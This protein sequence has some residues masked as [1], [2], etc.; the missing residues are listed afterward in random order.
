MTQPNRSADE[1]RERATAQWTSASSEGPYDSR[2]SRSCQRVCG[3]DLPPGTGEPP[4]GISPHR[5]RAGETRR[6]R[7]EDERRDRAAP[8]RTRT[9]TRRE[10]PTRG[11]FLS[12]GAKGIVATDFFHV[13][14]VHRHPSA[15]PG[16]A[17]P[18]SHHQPERPMGHTGGPKPRTSR[19]PAGDSG[20][21]TAT[22]TPSSPPPSTRCSPRSVSRPS[23]LGSVR[24]VRAR[25]PSGSSA[26]SAPSASII[27]SSSHDNI[28]NRCSTSTSNTTSRLV[29][30][31]A[32][33]SDSRSP[34]PSHS[35]QST[36]APSPASPSSA[37]SPTSTSA[38]PRQCFERET[39]DLGIITSRTGGNTRSP[40][41]AY[42]RGSRFAG[43]IET[44]PAGILPAR[45]G[46]T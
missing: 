1:D 20:S 33:T 26:P 8:P 5:R 35:R 15:E 12:E 45:K 16:R 2:S 17:R 21:S 14:T 43:N 19:M 28:S 34:A 4:V 11:Q 42:S 10:G 41:P 46:R 30:T 39:C 44:G 36:M 7:V 3:A 38:P 24:L 40:T 13:D 27:C 32:C 18:R 22:G 6:L 9:G 31:V 25:A 29:D 23:V 37:A